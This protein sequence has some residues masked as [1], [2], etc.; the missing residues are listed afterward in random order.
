[1]RLHE[2]EAHPGHEQ[3]VLAAQPECD[4]A[5]LLVIS[6]WRDLAGDRGIGFGAL[7]SIWWASLDRW[8]MRK[9]LDRE[10]FDMLVPVIQRLDADRMERD[11]A[12]RA[13]K[14]RGGG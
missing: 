10:L 5:M 6:A 3:D 14:G 9:G 1:M 2:R 11:A 12:A 4:A 7:G 13:L 8:A